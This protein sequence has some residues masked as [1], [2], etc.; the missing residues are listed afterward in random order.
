MKRR[1]G[2]GHGIRFSY[3]AA[4]CIQQEPLAHFYDYLGTLPFAR[5]KGDGSFWTGLL[6]RTATMGIARKIKFTRPVF[7]PYEYTR[8]YRDYHQRNHLLPIHAGNIVQ[9][10]RRAIKIFSTEA[11]ALP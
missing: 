9:S 3:T 2:F 10:G 6:G 4:P 7:V 11:L 5:A 8:R 1:T